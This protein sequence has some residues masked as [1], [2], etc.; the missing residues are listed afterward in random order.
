MWVLAM[1]DLPTGTPKA[2]KEY[3]KFRRSLLTSGYQQL[4]RSVYARH[5]GTK[6]IA[7][8]KTISLQRKLPPAGD[9][10]ILLVTD[11]QFARTKVFVGPEAADVEVAAPQLVMF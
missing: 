3:T 6:G 10:R 5:C 1:F 7:E 4:Q 11:R 9:V 8:M 2:R